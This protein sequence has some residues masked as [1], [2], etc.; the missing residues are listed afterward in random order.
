MLVL[1]CNINI[2]SKNSSKKLT[3]DYCK[4][5]NVETSIHNLTDTATVV[6]PKNIANDKKGLNFYI[7]KGDTIEI[8][9]W[10]VNH[11][12]NRVFSG[13]ITKITTDEISI[14]L[15]CQNEMFKFK[16]IDVK[17][18]I[19]KKFD[20]KDFVTK[21]APNVNVETL[22]SLSFGQMNIKVAMKLSNALDQI[23]QIYTYCKAFFE[24]KTLYVTMLTAP[25]ANRM[26][27]SLEYGRN[28]ISSSLSNSEID[29]DM[30]FAIKAVHIKADNSKIEI[31]EPI[32]AEDDKYN[33][34]NLKTHFCPELT[35]EKELREFAKN[36]IKEYYTS[37]TTGTLT[38]F[39]IP[40]IRKGDNI[41]FKDKFREEFNDKR[42][43]VFGVKTQ[44]DTNGY[45]QI[46][47]LGDELK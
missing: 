9:L 26:P 36:K 28:V 10:Y 4:E 44:F 5:I 30:Q 2:D 1:K 37:K 18:E 38:L 22:G 7:N 42:F 11:A 45:R 14:T 3:I 16:T 20:I 39:G 19:I 29:E 8:D 24:D 41:I 46:L 35:S 13:Y 6:L 34:Y 31:Y 15:N 32:D 33:I 12:K 40:A 47:T 23:M 21:Y 27:I 17:P 25:F 43:V